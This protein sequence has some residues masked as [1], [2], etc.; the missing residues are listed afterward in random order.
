MGPENRT[1]AVLSL[2]WLESNPVPIP[3]VTQGDLR[4]LQGEGHGTSLVKKK[5]TVAP[6]LTGHRQQAAGTNST[7]G[8]KDT[9]FLLLQ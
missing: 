7:T 2:Q 4:R 6:A 5:I 9:L 1:A 8:F 3:P